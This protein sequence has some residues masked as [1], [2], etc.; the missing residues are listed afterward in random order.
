MDIKTTV[1]SA[2]RV[3]LGMETTVHGAGRVGLG[4]ETTVHGVGR[5]TS[6][7]DTHTHSHTCTPS[8]R[9]T[10]SKERQGSRKGASGELAWPVPRAQPGR[11]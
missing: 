9:E 1:H 2:G 7:L 8:P 3:R 10:P 5:M 11:K 6:V 4:I